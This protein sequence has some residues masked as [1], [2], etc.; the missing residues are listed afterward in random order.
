[1]IFR[2]FRSYL[3]EKQPKHKHTS[4][5]MHFETNTKKHEDVHVEEKLDGLDEES[6]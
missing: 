6:S 5:T 1:M 3:G 2:E 4:Q